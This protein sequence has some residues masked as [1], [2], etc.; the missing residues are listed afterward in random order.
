MLARFFVDRPIFAWVISIVITLVGAVAYLTLPISQYP[1]ITPADGAG[2]RDL[3]G[4]ERQRGG[5][6]GGGADRAASQ[7]RR[8]H[9]LHVVAM[10]QRRRL[11]AHSDLRPW[12]SI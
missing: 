5:R 10:H 1:D 7:R 12:A 6:L 8:G 4:G 2:Q 11:C 3:S 9:A